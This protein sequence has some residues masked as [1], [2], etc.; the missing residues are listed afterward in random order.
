MSNIKKKDFY[1][2]VTGDKESID[3]YGINA[4]TFKKVDNVD[5]V[6]DSRGQYLGIRTC[7]GKIINGRYKCKVG[8]RDFKSF[9]DLKIW[10]G[11]NCPRVDL[12]ETKEGNFIQ[13]GKSV[14]NDN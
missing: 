12:I 8:I 14:N 13:L 7:R 5:M 2:V 1:N 4:S 6:F 11:I 10:G 3:N 9:M